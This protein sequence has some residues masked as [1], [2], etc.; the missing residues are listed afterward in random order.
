MAAAD[1]AR[2]RGKPLTVF[3]FDHTLIRVNSDTWIPKDLQA[4]SALA[5][6]ANFKSG[7]SWTRTM[8]AVVLAAQA[9]DGVSLAAMAA[10]ARR[11]PCFDE[12]TEALS[13]AAAVGPVD[14]VSDANAFFISEFMEEKG[15]GARVRSVYTNPVRKDEQGYLRVDPFHPWSLPPHGCDLCPL[16]MCKAEIL[17]SILSAE[18]EART[19]TQ[20]RERPR[21]VVYVGDGRGDWHPVLELTEHDVALVRHDESEPSALGLH[22]AILANPTRVRAQVVRWRDGSDLVRALRRV[23]S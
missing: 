17:R 7:D 1:E 18:S 5:V 22:R 19:Q 20:E 13:I 9:K 10:S 4:K 21:P 3:D 6:L 11:M 15:W 12:M 14:I 23:L 8:D 16:N 2:E